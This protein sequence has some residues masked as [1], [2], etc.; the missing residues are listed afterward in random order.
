MNRMLQEYQKPEGREDQLAQM[1][2]IVERARR[3]LLE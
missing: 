1:R 2:Q 3:E